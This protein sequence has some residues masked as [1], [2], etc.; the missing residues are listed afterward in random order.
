MT[1]VSLASFANFNSAVPW[2]LWVV[3][4][5]WLVGIS[6]GSFVLAMLGNLKGSQNLK[7]L[8]KISVILVWCV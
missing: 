5:V 7:A 2:G 8:T 4:Y 1:Q 6:V 3:I